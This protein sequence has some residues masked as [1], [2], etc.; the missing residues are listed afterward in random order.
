MHRNEGRV[1]PGHV[2]RGHVFDIAGSPT[3]AEARS[4]LRSIP[5]GALAVRAQG[6]IAWRGPFVELPAEFAS[7]GVSGDAGHFLLPGFVDAHVHLAQTYS[8]DAFGGGQLLDWLDSCVFPAEARLQDTAFASRIARDFTRRRVAAG[9]TS[10]LVFGSAFPEAQHELFEATERS[11]LRIV[12]GRGI[13]TVG[14]ESSAELLTTEATAL[15]LSAAEISRWHAADTGDAANAL[16]Q[17]ALVPRFSLSVTPTTLAG[18]GDLYD[19]VRASGV[20]FHSHLSENVGEI[21]A[22]ESVYDTRRYLDTYDGLFRPGSARGGS[23]LLGRRSIVA[24]AVHCTDHELSR[25]AE[26]GSSIAHCP[27]SQQFLASGT[28]PWRRTAD[29]GVNVAIGSDVGAGDE[30]LISRVLNDA[31]KVHLS[32]PG[33]ASVS[34]HPA[35]MLF[36]GTLAGARALDMEERYGNFDVGKDADFLVIEPDR[37]EPLA[38][39]LDNGIRA[40]DAE[41]AAEQTLFT[42]LM[43]LR[44]P[45]I[46]GVFVRGR[47][48]TPDYI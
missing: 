12:S 17:V 4:Q 20:Y 47:R 13:Q 41:R 29:F 37:W 35:E 21:A 34:L 18:L 11:G 2:Y 1:S 23:S 7:W 30:W 16:L 25:L 6:T 36:T 9:T 42:L 31:F 19:D 39:V 46:S 48:V 24:H 28:M 10:A 40:D 15:E 44:E 8:T 5:N 3:L 38:I 22:V 14:P 33:T 27:T 45:A 26:T 32:E 43:A